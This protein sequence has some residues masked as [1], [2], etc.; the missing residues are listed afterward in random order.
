MLETSPMHL[1]AH[2]Y[3]AMVA[4][5]GPVAFGSQGAWPAQKQQWAGTGRGG[6]RR[7]GDCVFSFLA[8]Q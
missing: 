1:K 8:L 6:A 3:F 7:A 4:V 2:R 5:T